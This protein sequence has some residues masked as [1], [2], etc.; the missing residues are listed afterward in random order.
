VVWLA[1]RGVAKPR[2]VER[3]LLRCALMGGSATW[4]K[5]QPS[6]LGSTVQRGYGWRYT[7]PSFI[8]K[9]TFITA[10]MSATGSP[11]MATMSARLPASI[12]P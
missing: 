8:T 10:V 3:S 1:V 4:P 9:S 5:E 6:K 11:G 12:T 2:R 7:L